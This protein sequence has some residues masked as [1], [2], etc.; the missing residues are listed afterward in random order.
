MRSLHRR[1]SCRK[2]GAF[3]PKIDHSQLLRSLIESID[4]PIHLR[5]KPPQTISLGNKGT[6]RRRRA[7]NPTE[8]L[9]LKT[10]ALRKAG[11]SGAKGPGDERLAQK[12]H[13]RHSPQR[14]KKALNIR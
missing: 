5:Q 12:N 13:R 8:M 7:L 3:D 1:R 10:K 11:L 9:L 14:T 6:E 2:T 4:Y